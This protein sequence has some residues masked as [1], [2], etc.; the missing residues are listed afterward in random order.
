MSRFCPIKTVVYIGEKI[1]KNTEEQPPG[2]LSAGRLF[3][4]SQKKGLL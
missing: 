3:L 4:L 1:K 2:F